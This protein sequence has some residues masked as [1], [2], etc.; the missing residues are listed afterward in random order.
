MSTNII[1]SSTFTISM[2]LL[3]A[4]LLSL[5]FRFCNTSKISYHLSKKTK[6]RLTALH[7][8]ALEGVQLTTLVFGLYHVYNILH[9]YNGTRALTMAAL[10]RLLFSGAGHVMA[11]VA[12]DFIENVVTLGTICHPIQNQT[13][14]LTRKV[15]WPALTRLRSG[16]G[17]YAGALVRTRNGVPFFT[18]MGLQRR[19]RVILV[20]SIKPRRTSA[21]FID[22]LPEM[23][24]ET[25][26]VRMI[27]KEA[28][29]SARR[30]SFPDDQLNTRP[31]L[32]DSRMKRLTSQ[33]SETGTSID[34]CGEADT[35]SHKPVRRRQPAQSKVSFER[36]GSSK[37][38]VRTLVG[39]FEEEGSRSRERERAARGHVAPRWRPAGVRMR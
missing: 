19:K 33:V 6:Q 11:V 7:A 34:T 15:P 22:A 2:L 1:S 14:I 17:E 10:V 28:K 16:K 9:I 26:P 13:L 39:T 4:L 25:L 38:K 8:F 32:H 37:G 12:V 29:T 3:L 18:H 20:H 36:P 27:A 5:T 21:S 23:R 31:L 35:P 30:H 24:F